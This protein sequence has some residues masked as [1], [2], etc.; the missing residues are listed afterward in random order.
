MAPSESLHVFP[1]V[2]PRNRDPSSG[3]QI[4]LALVFGENKISQ[5][6]WSLVVDRLILENFGLFTYLLVVSVQ[7][8]VSYRLGNGIEIRLSSVLHVDV[9]HVI[10]GLAQRLN[11]R[12]AFPR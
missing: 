12:L 7:I 5:H 1:S 3:K 10:A 2:R 6:S 4:H 9:V 11:H 8:T